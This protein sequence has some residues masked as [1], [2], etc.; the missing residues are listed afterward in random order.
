[1]LT[2]AVIG[3]GSIGQHHARVYRS[4]D[5]V[6]LAGV[7]DPDPH[8]ARTVAS[9]NNVPAF[10]SLDELFAA[11]KIDFASVAAPTSLHFEIGMALIERGVA[12]LMEKPLASTVSQGEQ[13]V[14]AA[15]ER[16]VLLATGH[17]ERFNPAIVELRK[18][19]SKGMAGRVH[20][21]SAQ[22]L[23]PYPPRIRDVGVV[24]DLASHDIDLLRF[25][26]G[27]KIIRVYGETLS[28]INSDRE[29]MFNGL[30]R[31]E[32]GAVGILDVNWM[33]P[34]KVRIVT[35]T[36]ACGHY[37][38]DLLSQE[39]FFYENEAAPSQWDAHSVLHGV[40]EG[41]VLG[42]R[43]QRQE[44]LAAELR[45]FVDAV[46]DKRAPGVTGEDG[47]ETL[48]LALEFVSSG[49]ANAE[50]IERPVAPAR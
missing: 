13:L 26:V 24:V 14:K 36:G 6:Q 46:R 19:L 43:I 15:R 1:M 31:F 8:A 32:G 48:R 5:G 7:V 34:K 4:L 12:V 44:P 27:E 23:S 42:I 39:L 28:G 10:S 11:G 2:G 47:L 9:R 16:N 49:S 21:V 41:N 30:M 38:C 29:D 18:Q 40:T 3:A 50:R 35:V 33:T 45:D 25:L 22:R 37:E 17:I 20:K